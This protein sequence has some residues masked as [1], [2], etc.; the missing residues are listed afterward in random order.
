MLNS[1]VF[2]QHN[3]CAGTIFFF[4][5]YSVHKI[6]IDVSKRHARRFVADK[7]AIDIARCSIELQDFPCVSSL[8]KRFN[9]LP[10]SVNVFC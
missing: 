8:Q 2:L 3:I 6:N 7:I 10:I 5:V 9:N 1:Y 4:N